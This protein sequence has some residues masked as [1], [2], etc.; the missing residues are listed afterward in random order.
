MSRRRRRLSQKFLQKRVAFERTIGVS[1]N[2]AAGRWLA[3]HDPELR[4]ARAGA[5]P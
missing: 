3:R 5:K 4:R 1:S 2:D